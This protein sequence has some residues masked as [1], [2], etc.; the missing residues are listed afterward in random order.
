MKK[1]SN[2]YH[3]LGADYRRCQI[4]GWVIAVVIMIIIILSFAYWHITHA[5]M[6]SNYYHQVR[7]CVENYKAVNQIGVRPLRDVSQCT[8]TPTTIQ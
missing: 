4:W 7:V 5:Q 1:H 2:L 8:H 6:S 3:E